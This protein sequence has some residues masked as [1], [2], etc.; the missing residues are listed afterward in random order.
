VILLHALSKTTAK[1]PASDIKSAN[2]RWA[3]FKQRMEALAR[4]RPRAIGGDA[5]YGLF[6][7]IKY[8]KLSER[9][10]W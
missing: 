1:I 7:L 4:E 8:G 3:D 2:E 10:A 9:S 6:M 5:P